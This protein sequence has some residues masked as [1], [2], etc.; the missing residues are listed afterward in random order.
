MFGIPRVLPSTLV[1]QTFGADLDNDG[2]ITN[3][4]HPDGG[5]DINDQLAFLALFQ[6]GDPRGD[7][8]DNT[9]WPIP[10]AAVDLNDL[11]HF[12]QLFEGGVRSA[13]TD[14]RFGWRGYQWDP[15]L[16][17]YHVRNRV[18][19]PSLVSWLQP[20]PLGD[21][22]GPNVYAYVGWDP[23]NKID[24]FGL[25]AWYQGWGRTIWYMAG[26]GPSGSAGQVW[27]ALG[28]GAAGGVGGEVRGAV[29]AARELG[30]IA[31]DLAH[32]GDIDYHFRSALLSRFD[33]GGL[34]ASCIR[35]AR[36]P[37]GSSRDRARRLARTT[38]CPPLM[39][40]L[41]REMPT[42]SAKRWAGSRSTTSSRPPR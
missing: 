40:T 1:G 24:P 29:R 13:T 21:I 9:G 33:Q 2:D 37:P 28:S 31:T 35:K 15:Y 34:G 38:C 11:I 22:D 12:L 39:I 5:V 17:I 16:N 26:F 30:N 32:S 25:E 41:G 3:G 19:D 4:L 10:D 36:T 6:A 7:M 18:F 23:F 27:G 14:A 42:L 20:D 8:C